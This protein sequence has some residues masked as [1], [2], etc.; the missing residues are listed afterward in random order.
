MVFEDVVFDNNIFG[1]DVTIKTMYDRVTQ[2][3]SSNTTSSNT[4]SLNS[5][6]QVAPRKMVNGLPLNVLFVRHVGVENLE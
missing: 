1:I 5:E 6:I 2:L 3:L 4:T